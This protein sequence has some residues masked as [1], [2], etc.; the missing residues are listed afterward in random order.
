MVKGSDVEKVSISVKGQ[1]G[2]LT[3]YLKDME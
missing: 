2:A 3:K 1:L